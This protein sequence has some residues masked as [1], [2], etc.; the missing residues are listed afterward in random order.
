[1]NRDTNQQK[2]KTP[3]TTTIK[4]HLLAGAVAISTSIMSTTTTAQHNSPDQTQASLSSWAITLDND[5]LVPASRDQDYTYGLNIKAAG[6]Q[7]PHFFG[8]L[9]RPLGA[10]DHWI[11]LSNQPASTNRDIEYGLYGFTPEQID[12]SAANHD[13]RPFASIVYT[14][15]SHTYTDHDTGA[16][17]RT[18]LTIGVLGLDLVGDTQNEIH[19]LTNSDPAR[20]W[21]QQISDGGELTGRYSIAKQTTLL[22]P[23]PGIAV[24]ST[25]QGSIGYITEASWG[26]NLMIGD[27]TPHSGPNPALTTYAEQAAQ[28]L[29]NTQLSTHH[30]VAGFAVKARLYNAFLQGQFRDSAVD[31]DHGDLNHTLLEGW[32][33]AGRHFGRH[34]QVNYLLRGHSSEITT[35]SGDR[36]VIWGGLTLSYTH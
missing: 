31:Y 34:W 28:T 15:S 30:F 23:T 13:D 19:R 21:D 24:T 18:A 22:T 1:M 26:I 12:Q 20:G 10:I 25:T 5:I 17:W 7:T 14:T 2:A 16:T 32:I 6:D 11:G 9:H 33:G 8:S 35:G 3:I 27:T 29:G 4:N 36:N